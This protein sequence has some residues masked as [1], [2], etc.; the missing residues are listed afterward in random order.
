MFCDI[1]KAFDRVWHAG[2]IKANRVIGVSGS[3]LN[4]FKIE[5]SELSYQ[6]LSPNGVLYAQ[7]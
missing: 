4:W 3:L 1:S 7:A 2:L 6:E 5:S